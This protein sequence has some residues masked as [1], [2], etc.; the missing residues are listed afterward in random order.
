MRARGAAGAGEQGG[1]E[2]GRGGSATTDWSAT[3]NWFGLGLVFL[4]SQSFI[5]VT[6]PNSHR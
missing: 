4:C 5:A 3:T 6:T 1:G 2:R